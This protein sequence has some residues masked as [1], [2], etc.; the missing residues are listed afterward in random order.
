[1]QTIVVT[2]A[3]SGIGFA[4]TRL[5]L[6]EGYRVLGWDQRPGRLDEINSPHLAF[7][8][9]DVRD[10]AAMRQSA[11]AEADAGHVIAGLVTCAAIIQRVP[12]LELDEAT[13]DR[14]I[15]INLKGTMFACQAVLPMMRK[16]GHGSIV[17]FSSSIARAGSPTGAHY[18]ASKGG[19]L[20][21]MRS[22]ALEVAKE[23]IRVNA[24]SPGVT[25]TPQPRGHATDEEL[26]AKAARIPLGR[27]GQPEDM[28]QAIHFLLGNESSYVTGQDIRINGGGQIF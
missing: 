27:I 11:G 24:I 20:G 16:A 4:A 10:L 15:D 21:L 6:E 23:G 12:Y 5:L 3:G 26:Y 22:L 2:G 17:V 7:C 14:H 18:A 8:A 28:A 13:F 25:D 1:M 19:V 9:L